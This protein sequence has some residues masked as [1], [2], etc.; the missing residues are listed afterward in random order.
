MYQSDMKKNSKENVQK[1]S[2]AQN[3]LL[4]TIRGTVNKHDRHMLQT[5]KSKETSSSFFNDV[6]TTL[7]SIHQTQLSDKKNNVQKQPSTRIKAQQRLANKRHKERTTPEL[8]PNDQMLKLPWVGWGGRA[9]R[10]S[11]PSFI[12]GS[13]IVHNK[14][15]T[16]KAQLERNRKQSGQQMKVTAMLALEHENKKVW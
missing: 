2:Q 7:E 9:N 14:Y 12:V 3:S 11:W 10:V 15:Q 16:Y 1:E 5:N 6:I 8:P 4:M 13:H